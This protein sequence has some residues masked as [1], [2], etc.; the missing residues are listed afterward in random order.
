[1]A[2]ESDQ[3]SFCIETD[4]LD[5]GLGDWPKTPWACHGLATGKPFSALK[6]KLPTYHKICSKSKLGFSKSVQ[7]ILKSSE[8][9]LSWL[10]EWA[11]AHPTEQ[12]LPWLI[13]ASIESHE[14]DLQ[15][16]YYDRTR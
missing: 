2:Q 1:M 6:W 12:Y 16:I 5:P 8:H 7:N 14:Q 4:H 9:V 10:L 3:F 11:P 15:R 13:D